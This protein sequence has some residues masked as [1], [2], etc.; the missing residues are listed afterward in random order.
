MPINLKKKIIFIHIPKCSGTR[1]N[2][3]F[4]MD[5][6]NVL[7]SCDN[8]KLSRTKQHYPYFLIKEELENLNNYYIF[9]I[10]RNP[11]R[12]YVS[13][14]N[15][16][17]NRCAKVF[18]NMINNMDMKN[19]AKYLLDRIKNEGYDFL[20]YGAFHQFEPSIFYIEKNNPDI[21]IIKMDDKYNDNIKALC[22]KF[23]IE[24]DNNLILN[25]NGNR[26]HGEECYEEIMK[27]EE[28]RNILYTIYEEDF[29]Y[30]EFEK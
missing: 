23:N 12:R 3:L 4:D 17:P 6:H 19:F 14:Y 5:T 11:Y 18:S 28:Y 13:A 25:A 26:D 9:T 2:K 7:H 16:Y 8:H 10:V 29:K 24:Y 15:Q 21:H 27:D 20:K 30:F 22:K 1:I